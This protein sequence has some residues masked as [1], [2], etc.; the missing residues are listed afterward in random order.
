ME[1]WRRR[2]VAVVLKGHPCTGK[3][4]LANDLARR[5]RCPLLDKDDIKSVLHGD[6]SVVEDANGLSLR[7]LWSVLRTQLSKGLTCVV[8]T[9]LSKA[10]HLNEVKQASDA[11]SAKLLVVECF[12][13]DQRVWRL[14]LEKRVA[15]EQNDG[16]SFAND[17]KPQSWEELQSL[18]SSYSGSFEYNPIELGADAYLKLD[19]SAVD[20]EM[21]AMLVLQH[22]KRLSTRTPIN[23]L[24]ESV[25]NEK[26]IDQ[27][28]RKSIANLM[29]T[30]KNME[31]VCREVLDG[32]LSSLVCSN[33]G[34]KT[35][36]A[37]F[38][39]KLSVHE[40]N[41]CESGALMAVP[42]E[43]LVEGA[44]TMEPERGLSLTDFDGYYSHFWFQDGDTL[45]NFWSQTK[46]LWRLQSSFDPLM[47][48]RRDLL[49]KA[50]MIRRIQCKECR[51]YLGFSV[52]FCKGP[53]G[54]PRGYYQNDPDPGEGIELGPH[55]GKA[56]FP[57]G[58]LSPIRTSFEEKSYFAFCCTH[59]KNCL[60]SS[61]DVVHNMISGTVNAFLAFIPFEGRRRSYM[62]YDALLLSKVQGKS[63]L[64]FIPSLSFFFFCPLS[65]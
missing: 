10:S 38:S 36:D 31:E 28:D 22:V 34:S 15:R 49:S 13:S 52:G 64:S 41:D 12:M 3:S 32:R 58:F 57:K 27:L 2:A 48:K 18:L 56:F 33:C 26:I 60:G 25:L 24:P 14:R 44:V 21:Q 29:C 59:C 53:A 4:T 16:S 1:E 63:L 55:F 23:L 9:T 17:H 65:R 46:R 8:D 5:L 35:F 11:C 61:K 47:W 45:G 30:C 42:E 7:I 39:V 37:K 20:L 50:K 43:H 51:L 54:P 40:I 6:P 62:E 19:T